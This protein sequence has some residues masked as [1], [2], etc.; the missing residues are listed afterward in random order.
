MAVPDQVAQGENYDFSQT[1]GIDVE[2]GGGDVSG[3][4]YRVDVKQFPD[5]TS[6]IS[7]ALIDVTGATVKGTLTPAETALLAVGLW[8]I[9]ITS[10]DPDEEIETTR[11][12]Q[13]TQ[14]WVA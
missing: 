13:I 1:L 10:V 5:D 11:R 14:A 4:T 9:I 8:Y 3:F 6:A 2:V 12:I 7:K